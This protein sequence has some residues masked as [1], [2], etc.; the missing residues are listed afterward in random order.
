MEIPVLSKWW[1]VAFLILIGLLLLPY[2]IIL[3]ICEF[4]NER[5]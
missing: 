2:F 1:E 4:I 3:F 5:L